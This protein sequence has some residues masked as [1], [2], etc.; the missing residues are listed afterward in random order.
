MKKNLV[1]VHNLLVLLASLSPNVSAG[2][3]GGRVIELALA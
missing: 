2:F 1:V 3:T